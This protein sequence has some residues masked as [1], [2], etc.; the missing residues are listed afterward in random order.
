MA[1]LNT[2][3]IMNVRYFKDVIQHAVFVIKRRAQP[4]LRL[5]QPQL[6]LKKQ[7]LRLA[8]V[9]GNGEKDLLSDYGSK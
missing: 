1:P 8:T 2:A 6:R 7:Q 3:N 4:Q 9:T 5:P